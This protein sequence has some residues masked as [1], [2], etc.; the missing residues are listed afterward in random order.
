MIGVA[1]V[2]ALAEIRRNSMRAAL[3]TLGIV[4]GVG[5][6]IAMVTLGNG[7]QAGIA[8]SIGS[9]GRNLIIL[10]PG[11]R[12]GPGGP[13]ADAPPFDLADAAL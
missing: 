8:A 5:A 6:V 10:T 13:S 9:L 11:Q 2:I 3:T 4:I 7:A 1:F 12:R